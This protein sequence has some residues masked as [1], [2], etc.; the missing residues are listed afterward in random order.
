M[1]KFL[2]FINIICGISLL[3]TTIGCFVNPSY[4]WPLAFLGFIFPFFVCI[5]IFLVLFWL[6]TKNKKYSLVSLIPLLFTFPFLHRTFTISTHENKEKDIKIISYNVRNF[7][8]YNW[9]HNKE[10]RQ[11]MFDLLKEEAPDILCLQEFYN[12]TMRFNNIEDLKKTLGFKYSYYGKTVSIKGKKGLRTWGIITLSKYP[13]I[14]Q[15]KID[16][17]NSTGNTCIYTDIKIK[18]QIV[19]VYNVHMQSIHFGYNDYKYIDQIQENQE[20]NSQKT[21]NILRKIKNAAVKRGK[22]VNEVLE[23]INACEN[24][25]IIC[26]DFNDPPVSYTYQKLS[27]NMHDAHVQN[28]FGFGR[29]YSKIIPT[30]RIDYLLFDAAIQINSY[31]TI[32]KDYSDHYPIISTFSLK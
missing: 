12:D 31:K 21:E 3:A 22:Q 23:S 27:K 7:D 15:D 16:F 26:G 28:G 4:Y 17:Y 20:T 1:K 8:L 6:L 10:T 13:I 18:N 9:S 32:E 19:R 25:K 30:L 14:D 11:K 29:T 24:P 2:V 5:N